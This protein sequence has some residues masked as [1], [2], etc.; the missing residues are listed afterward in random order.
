MSNKEENIELMFY[1]VRLYQYVLFKG[2]HY[3]D[4]AKQATEK[5]RKG[6][7]LTA[8]DF[9]QIYKDLLMND[10]FDIISKDLCNLFELLP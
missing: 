5:F 6:K 9:E 3:R 2:D 8:A 10:L 7:Y 4:K 1:R